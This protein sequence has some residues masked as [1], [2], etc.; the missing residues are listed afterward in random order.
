Y[1][2]VIGSQYDGYWF[3]SPD[4]AGQAPVITPKAGDVPVPAN[5]DNTGKAERAIVRPAASAQWAIAGPSGTYSVFFGG[6]GDVPVP[7]AYNA[8]A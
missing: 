2:P 7:G 4:T 6:A 5:Y 1:R 3:I 8:T